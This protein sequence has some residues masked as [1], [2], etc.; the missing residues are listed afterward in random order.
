VAPEAIRWAIRLSQTTA[1]FCNQCLGYCLQNME[2]GLKQRRQDVPPTQW[3]FVDVWKLR[4]GMPFK[5][6]LS[7][8]SLRRALAHQQNEYRQALPKLEEFER[9]FHTGEAKLRVI[10]QV[11][12]GP[13]IGEQ[14]ESW[15]Q[16][17]RRM[18]RCLDIKPNELANR[19]IAAGIVAL[20]REDSDYEPDF[21]VEYRQKVVIPKIEQFENEQKLAEHFNAYSGVPQ[22]LE[23]DGWAFMR[24]IEVTNLHYRDLVDGFMERK[25]MEE[26]FSRISR[27]KTLSQTY[28][29]KLK[30]L[31]ASPSY[32]DWSEP[33]PLRNKRLKKEIIDAWVDDWHKTDRAK[34]SEHNL[35]AEIISQLTVLSDAELRVIQHEIALALS[36]RS[37]KGE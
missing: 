26:G 2:R 33:H 27:D 3:G 12:E 23:N 24:L 22:E 17:L 6:N 16:K 19:M 4:Q 32:Q 37:G 1:G 35:V 10:F 29:D 9:A 30:E 21:I 11:G 36:L 18:A 25:T 31:Y 15:S 8:A 28:V 20:E 34:P 7:A 14:A 5:T 13:A